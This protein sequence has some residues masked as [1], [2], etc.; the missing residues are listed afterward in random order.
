MMK[1]SSK[2]RPRNRPPRVRKGRSP[3]ERRNE[4]IEK[5][6]HHAQPT[7][8][9]F[10]IEEP[11]IVFNGGYA[12]VDP[13]E[14]L[15]LYGPVNPSNEPISVGIVGTG[16]GITAFKTLL[17]K[18]RNPIS[19]G[20]N[21]AGDA[22]DPFCFPPFP[23]TG[24]C[25]RT[26][27]ETDPRI[28]CD[29]PL[30]L[31]EEAVSAANTTDKL[32][33]VIKLVVEKLATLKDIEP[34]PN[35]V[36]VVFPYCVEE[37]CAAI[38]A[39]FRF[40]KLKPS[41]AEMMQ[42]SLSRDR[43]KGQMLFDLRLVLDE[44]K[45]SE[46]R[47]YWN[48]HHALKAHAMRTGLPTQMVWQSTLTDS[49]QNQ[50]PA[51]L[52]WNLFI[53]LYYKGGRIPWNL[54]AIPASTCFVG[55]SFYKEAPVPRALMQTSLA[56]VFSGHGEGIVLKGGRAQIDETKGDRKPHLSKEDARSLLE[57]ALKTYLDHHNNT[58]PERLVI[59]KTSRFWPD[60]V[61]GFK[62]ALGIIPRFDFVAL[63]KLGDRFMRLGYEPPLRGTVI[64][65]EKQRHV[66]FTHGYSPQ[67]GMYPGHRIPN[68]L[69]IVE[70]H[71]DSSV[72][73]L[74]REIMA[75]TKLNWNSCAFASAEP[76]TIQ[77]AKTIGRILTEVPDG[78]A[79]QS[80]YRFYM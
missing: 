6:L 53:A 52:A 22:F 64:S 69:E 34:E 74:C 72:E 25:F 4:D 62:S 73:T 1:T 48:I 3:D 46:E 80:K 35:V 5:L 13:K 20:V 16:D 31:F 18:A 78:S 70:H 58:L 47:G 41:R 21:R 60:E 51:T 17:E 59:H 37:E 56:Q 12:T 63:E 65:I 26:V 50:D 66:I 54:E 40:R 2:N 44:P 75:L 36:S 33:N 67:L 23:G 68:P 15:E 19:P 49:N 61:D 14:G 43:K 42:R 76:I 57:R 10:H 77:F 29:I 55:I 45:S 39:T 8:D 28:Q 27:F 32:R 11:R 9:G 7:F 24:A 30:R 71:G 79:I 38:G